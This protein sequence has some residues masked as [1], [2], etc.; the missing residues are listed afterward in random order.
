MLAVSIFQFRKKM[1]EYLEHLYL[2]EEPII[3]TRHGEGKA[4]L[5]PL[6]EFTILKRI[7]DD[8]KMSENEKRKQRLRLTFKTPKKPPKKKKLK[9]RRPR[10]PS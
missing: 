7:Q 5:I 2:T 8:F 3:I 4:V 10:S 1:R 9:K 6:L